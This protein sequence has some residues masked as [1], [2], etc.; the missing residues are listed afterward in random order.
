M[1]GC[2]VRVG[3]GG[4]LCLMRGQLTA[5]KGIFCIVDLNRFIIALREPGILRRATSFT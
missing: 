4:R 5:G 2:G 1:G 3:G